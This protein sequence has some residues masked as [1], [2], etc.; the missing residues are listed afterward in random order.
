MIRH[1]NLRQVRKQNSVQHEKDSIQNKGGP[2]SY[3]SG[4]MV[5]Q[6][7]QDGFLQYLK[8]ANGSLP[9]SQQSQYQVA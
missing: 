4:G 9:G 5:K 6:S 1:G 7:Q 3:D 2:N 8:S